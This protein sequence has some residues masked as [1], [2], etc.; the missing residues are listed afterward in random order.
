[1][2]IVP[3]QQYITD[4][5]EL[6]G[7]LTGHHGWLPV[8]KNDIVST[9][10]SHVDFNSYN[11][12]DGHLVFEGTL[13]AVGCGSGDKIYFGAF[14]D[15]MVSKCSAENGCRLGQW[16]KIMYTMEFV[17]G[18]SSCWSMLGHNGRGL[19]DVDFGLLEF[20]VIEDKLSKGNWNGETARCDNVKD[21]FLHAR[22]G[23]GNK[24][25]LTVQQKRDLSVDDAGIGSAFS[26]THVGSVVRYKD[27]YVYL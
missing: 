11:D 27:I 16:T 20:N 2:N 7:I 22:N 4:L 21:N 10:S 17:S 9:I 19:E 24:G 26:C 8:A 13:R 1:M 14:F 6:D 25:T 5:D 3:M 12:A 18:S 15:N 23:K